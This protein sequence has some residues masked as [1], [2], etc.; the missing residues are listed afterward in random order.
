VAHVQA[1]ITELCGQG[2]RGGRVGAAGA[3]GA[4]QDEARL[5]EG[6]GELRKRKGGG[7][8]QDDWPKKQKQE[9]DEPARAGN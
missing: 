8:I 5:G 4:A 9:E 7:V 6:Q 2:G 1:A 3:A